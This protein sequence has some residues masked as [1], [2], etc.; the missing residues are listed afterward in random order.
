MKALE[1]GSCEKPRFERLFQSGPARAGRLVTTHGE[2]ATPAFMPV[3]TAGSVKSL[4]PRQVE[5]LGAEIVL[6]NTYHLMLR[7]GADRVREL[8]GIHRFM[9]WAKPVLTDSGGFQ[10][11]SLAELRR[12]EDEGVTFR[13]HLDGSLHL[14]TPERAVEIQ[15]KLGSDIAMVLDECLLYP[16]ERTEVRTAAQRSREWA[17]R[18]KAVR[19]RQDQALFGIVQGGVFEDLRRENARALVELDLDGYG[20]GGL[21]VGEPKELLRAMTGTSASE[22]PEDR[23]RYLM[24][25]GTPLDILESVALGV[26]L[27]DCVLPTRNAR[28]GTLF[29]SAGRIAIKNARYAADDSPLD[30]EC[31][32]YTCAHFSR[33]YLRHLFVAREM[34]SATL[35][36][37]HNLHFYVELMSRIRR[38]IEEDRFAALLEASSKAALDEP[39]G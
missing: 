32:C 11:A 23:P 35:N 19:N 6:S 1:A 14:L 34:T 5:E 9:N 12:V 30:P 20:I 18:A 13:S 21:A 31:R 3:A 4:T 26:D 2:V 8:G 17:K 37:I 24:G 28:N 16:A 22:L 15:E 29:T 10:V 38:A 33:A 39:A 36:T 7:P 27:F 25:V